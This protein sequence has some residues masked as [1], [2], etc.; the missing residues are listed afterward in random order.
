MEQITSWDICFNLII[1]LAI[2]FY[3]RGQIKRNTERNGTFGGFCIVIILFSTFGFCAGDFLHYE[4]LYADLRHSNYNIHIEPF[5]YWLIKVLPESYYIWRCA[6]WGTAAI[7]LVLIFKRLKLNAGFAIFIFSLLLM[8][9]FPAPRQSLGYVVLLYGFVLIFFS[10]KSKAGSYILGAV[11][12]FLSYFLHKSMVVYAIM[13]ALALIPF[14]KWIYMGS[15]FVFPIIY[16]SMYNLSSYVIA[17][18]IADESTQE[19][20]ERYLNS[21]FY[22]VAN[23]NGLVQLGIHRIP[24]LVLLILAIWKL[25]FKKEGIKYG[26]KV[27]LQYA[28][29]LIYVSFLFNGQAV[30]AFLSPRFWDAALY[31]LTIFMI[32]FLYRQRRTPL[33]KGCFY[34]LIL[35][36]L[37]DFAYMLY[38]I[39]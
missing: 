6:V 20:G 3:Y 39:Q 17:S 36:N 15:L 35:A 8:L 7:I 25:Y 26:Y 2:L 24:I 11:L 16:R 10:D 31:P 28:Y 21:D 5:Y 23:A 14:S 27:L 1:W 30:S 29:I 4:S 34:M 13:L 32:F 19:V 12:V 33:I 9:Y 37:Y 18:A 22:Q 38:K